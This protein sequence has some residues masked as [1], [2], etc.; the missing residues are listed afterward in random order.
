MNSRWQ[1]PATHGLSWGALRALLGEL[2]ACGL[3]AS[4]MVITRLQGTLTLTGGVTVRCCSG[5]LVWPTG[6]ASRQGRPLQTLHSVYDPSGAAR[7][8]ALLAHPDSNT[9]ARP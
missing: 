1:S 9:A 6:R 5:W 4:G 8:L 7:R 2:D 3:H